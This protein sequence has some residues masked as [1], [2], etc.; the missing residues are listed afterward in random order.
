[1]TG[2][3]A[4]GTLAEADF[5]GRFSNGLLVL[6]EEQAA[7]TYYASFVLRLLLRRYYYLRDGGG[8]VDIFADNCSSNNSV[9]GRSDSGYKRIK[10]RRRSANND[11]SSGGFRVDITDQH[12]SQIVLLGG[13]VLA[14]FQQQSPLLW[15]RPPFALT[16]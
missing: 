7:A 10:D 1:V 6:L 4:A 13:F 3:S 15:R 12:Q 16:K 9:A 8:C 14:V 11:H 5:L 2:E